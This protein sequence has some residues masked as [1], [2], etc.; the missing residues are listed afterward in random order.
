MP[1]T[2]ARMLKV[3]DEAS[4]L[5]AWAEELRADLELILCSDLSDNSALGAIN[6]RLKYGPPACVQCAIER[7]HFRRARRRNDSSAKRMR[8]KR[9]QQENEQ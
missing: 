3:L 9:Q 7:D 8:T 2:Q 6:A 1:I 4:A 5:S